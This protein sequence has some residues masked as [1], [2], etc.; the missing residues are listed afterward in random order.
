[1]PCGILRSTQPHERQVD[2]D[3]LHF[4]AIPQR[5]ARIRDYQ[6]TLAQTVTYLRVGIGV[7][8]DVNQPRFDHIPTHHLHARTLRPV[9]DRRTRNGYSTAAIC[10]DGRARKHPHPKPGVTLYGYAGAAKLR[11]QID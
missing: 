1:R 11:P 4:V 6:I 5:A 10:L 2:L 9:E 8:A 3:G 7:I